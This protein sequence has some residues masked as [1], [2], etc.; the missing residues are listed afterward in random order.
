[1]RTY[2][3]QIRYFEQDGYSNDIVEFKSPSFITWRRLKKIIQC[4]MENI[5]WNLEDDRCNTVEHEVLDCVAEEIG[6]GTTWRYLNTEDT[7]FIGG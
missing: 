1:M 6:Y 4:H 5:D 2:V 7:F 3:F